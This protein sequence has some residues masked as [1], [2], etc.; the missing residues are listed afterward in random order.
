MGIADAPSRPS[1]RTIGVVTTSFGDPYA[2]QLVS[3][4]TEVMRQHD[5][6]LICFAGGRP[7]SPDD[8]E[9]GGSVLYDLASAQNIDGVLLMS[10][11][12]VHFL[13]EELLEQFAKRYR[14][15]PLITIAAELSGRPCVL[16]DSEAGLREVLEHLIDTHCHRRIGF[17]RGPRQ[18]AEAEIRY[19]VF[20]KVMAE[21]AITIEPEWVVMGTFDAR[22]GAV[23]ARTLFEERQL[24]LHAVV[25][26]NDQMAIAAMETLHDLGLEVPG[27][28]AVVGFD[29]TELSGFVSPA[30]TT[31]KQPLYR[32]GE[33]AAETLLALLDGQAVP[34]RAVLATQAVIRE[35]CGCAPKLAHALTLPPAGTRGEHWKKRLGDAGVRIQGELARNVDSPALQPRDW[36]KQLLAALE[37]E[38]EGQNAFLPFLESLVARISAPGE[39]VWPARWVRGWRAS[40]WCAQRTPGIAPKC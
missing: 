10:G 12:L 8:S 2:G 16:V 28:V 6:N 23:A 24:D 33:Q 11:T 22:S 37:Q 35:S 4:V 21:R 31:V 39:D 32:L 30:L 19:G 40:S 7:G 20:C 18:S 5:V 15:L 26:A 14:A 27:D 9:S 1:R 25:A 34:A 36:R 13:G 29:D 38:L 3:G 17:I